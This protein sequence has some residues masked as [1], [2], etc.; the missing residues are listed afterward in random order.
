MIEFSD[1]SA[2][3]YLTSIGGY[4]LLDEQSERSLARKMQSGDKAAREAFI[5]AN[6]RLVASVAKRYVGQGLGLMDL[7]MA[8]NEGLLIAVGKY[9]PDDVRQ[10]RFTTMAYHWIRTAIVRAVAETGEAVRLPYEVFTARNRVRRLEAPGQELTHDEL[11]TTLDGKVGMADRVRHAPL[12]PISLDEPYNISDGHH[13]DDIPTTY[14]DVLHDP[15]VDV[16]QEVISTDEPDRHAGLRAA[17]AQ[18]PQ[19]DQEVLSLR[20]GLNADGQEHSP[21]EVAAIY[22][23]TTKTAHAW[24]MAALARMRCAMTAPTPMHPLA[25]IQAA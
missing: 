1:P 2:R 14:G 5:H 10:T 12:P 20:F 17:I 9:D 11:C 4:A 19:R 22:H 21:R 18:L 16:E 23:V 3:V 13:G 7:I 24:E 8:G 15:R 25:V 6:L